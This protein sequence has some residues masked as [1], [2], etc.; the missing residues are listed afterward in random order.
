M[1][2][3][4]ESED[5]AKWFKLNRSSINI[6]ATVALDE[7]MKKVNADRSK[8]D[9]DALHNLKC[10]ISNSIH[11]YAAE[12]K[13]ISA[14]LPLI[15]EESFRLASKW[16]SR[17]LYCTKLKAKRVLDP[18]SKNLHGGKT[19]KEIVK[20]RVSGRFATK[21]TNMSDITNHSEIEETF[22][23]VLTDKMKR[24]QK[25]D[26]NDSNDSYLENAQ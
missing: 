19:R 22:Y 1:G 9:S 16:I 8:L 11:H 20:R 18:T 3:Q 13:G 15:K 17:R 10:D 25:I 5:V 26:Q 12:F 21:I 6:F 23:R 24:H 2:L 7:A 14:I 4:V